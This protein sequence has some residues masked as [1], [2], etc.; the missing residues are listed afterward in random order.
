MK[1]IYWKPHNLPKAILVGFCLFIITGL[2]FVEHFK[3]LTYQPYYKEKLAA[4]KL[5]AKAFKAIRD[6]RL[7]QSISILKS[8]DPQ[9]SGLIGRQITAITSDSSQLSA[10]QTTINPNTAALF[11]DWLKAAKLK[12]GDFVA[13]NMTGS[14]P[15]LDIAMLSAIKTLELKPVITYSAAASQFGANIPYFSWLDMYHIL[16]TE[17]LFTY[18]VRGVSLGGRRDKAYEMSPYGVK[19]LKE[20]IRR[21]H[22]PFIDSQGTIDG[23]DKRMAIYDVKDDPT[24]QIAAFIN[25]GGNMASIGLKKVDPNRRMFSSTGGRHSIV[26]GIVDKMPIYLANTDSVAVRY[27]KRGVPVINVHNIT[28]VLVDKYKYPYKPIHPVPIGTGSMFYEKEYNTWLAMLVLGVDI[29][30][31]ILIALLSR[32]YMLRYKS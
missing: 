29:T 10:K 23:I 2:L 26:T 3:R 22:Y 9:L 4:T 6:A 28:A 5:T 25:V 11:I 32:K 13:V 19:V 24:N 8:L 18:P 12:K 17:K 15:A 20:T 31:F 30:V 27:L 1:T 21:Y 16:S 14:F 7:N